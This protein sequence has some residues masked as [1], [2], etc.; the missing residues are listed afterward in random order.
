[1]IVKAAKDTFGIRIKNKFH[2]KPWMTADIKNAIDDYMRF[3]K[4]FYSFS[5]RKK[6]IF[7]DELNYYKEKKENLINEG[8][9]NW[10]KMVIQK[11]QNKG[12]M[13]WSDINK[14]IN[15]ETCK[16]DYIPN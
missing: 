5:K 14:I 16:N 13:S 3:K 7:K 12:S 2:S 9:L 10:I 6:K 1:M 4:D 8:K 11:Q 15:Y